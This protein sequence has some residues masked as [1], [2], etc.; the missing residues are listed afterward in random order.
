MDKD[1]VPDSTEQNIRNGTESAY[2]LGENDFHIPTPLMKG[3]IDSKTTL[4]SFTAKINMETKTLRVDNL[5]N[6]GFYLEIDLNN[7]FE[8]LQQREEQRKVE[9]EGTSA[10]EVS[11][12]IARSIKS[13]RR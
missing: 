4:R 8:Q 2:D 3:R 5:D 13:R 9:S 11:A 12:I 10:A 1:D 7:F 6:L